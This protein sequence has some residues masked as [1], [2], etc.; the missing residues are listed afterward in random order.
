MKIFIPSELHTHE[1]QNGVYFKLIGA[2]MAKLWPLDKNEGTVSFEAS[3]P[4]LHCTASFANG[5]NRTE[6]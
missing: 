6:I 4:V 3:S 5:T 1:D 2:S